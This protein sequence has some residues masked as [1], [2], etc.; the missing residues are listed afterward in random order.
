MIDSRRDLWA[1][2]AR[3]DGDGFLDWYADRA[4]AAAEAIVRD[5]RG[6]TLQEIPFRPTPPL[7]IAFEEAGRMI[8]GGKK[9][10]GALLVLGFAIA[11]GEADL[12]DRVIDASI[13][14]EFLHNAFLVHDD[15]MD[16]ASERR[17]RPSAWRVF[18]TALRDAADAEHHGI[19]Q[20]INLGDI[21]A[22]WGP[23]LI[24]HP[25]FPGDRAQQA[26]RILNRT[27]QATVLGQILDVDP[28]MRLDT[29]TE[30]YVLAI[31]RNKTAR[32]SFVGPLEIGAV[33]GGMPADDPAL[34]AMESYGIPVGIAFQLKDD[35]LGVY[36]DERRVGKPVISDL[37]EGKKTLLFL[38]LYRR[39]DEGDRERLISFWGNIAASEDRDLPW[40]RAKGIAT[41]A[42]EVVLAR[43]HALVAEARRSIPGVSRD[44]RIQSLLDQIAEF[45]IQRDR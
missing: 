24:A 43:L 35:Y 45:A 44:P 19:S 39:L 12:V 5:R 31:A 18:S 8:S 32:Y 28:A 15:I 6:E 16:R 4:E 27:V 33:L 23:L 7:S 34:Q 14:Y 40:V 1:V 17:S 26:I 42:V 11:G 9:L 38:E 10:R 37:A 29:L 3:A 22:F 21:I 36:G 20:A 30:D 41:G 25:A 13:G 2:L